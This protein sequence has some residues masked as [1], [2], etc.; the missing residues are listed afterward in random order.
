MRR[1]RTGAAL[2]ILLV[3]AVLP[4]VLPE[5]LEFLLTVALAK[6]LVVLGVAVL[7]RSSLVS[8][9]HGLYFAAGAYTVGLAGKWLG[10]HDALLLIPLGLGVSGGLAALLGLILARYRGIFFGMLTLA[11]SM[12]LYSLLLKVYS[13]TG[14]TDGMVIVPPTVLGLAL[15]ARAG[16]IDYALTLV[17]LVLALWV[18]RRWLG[19]P[20]GYLATAIRDNEI[21]VEYMGASVRQGIYWTYVL[22]GALGGLGGTLVAFTVGHIAP[23]FSYWTQSGDFVFV[24]VLG[25]YSSVFAPVTGSVVFELVRNYAYALSPYTWQMSLGVILLLI[26]LFL[27]RGLWTLWERIQPE[28]ATWT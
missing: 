2:G 7:L 12:I 9:G 23:E 6:A 3:L 28:V 14:G 8:F 1:V 10:L 22:S 17:C 21:R 13:V 26:V 15:G 25:G 24:T 20:L 11:F 5:W 4:L 27:P 18:T 16:A 19:S